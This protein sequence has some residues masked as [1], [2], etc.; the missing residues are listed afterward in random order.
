VAPTG[1]RVGDTLA[2]S[3]TSPGETGCTM[4]RNDHCQTEEA[5]VLEISGATV[6]LSAPLRHDHLVE[7]KSHGGRTLLMRA[8]VANLRRNVRFVGTEEDNSEGFGA[9]VMLMHPTDGQS[10]FTHVELARATR[11]T[12]TAWTTRAAWPTCTRPRSSAARSTVQTTA[13]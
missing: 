1:W 4:D 10:E 12:S 11:C 8:E 13:A 9:H 5:T 6:F 3:T 7:S 2:I